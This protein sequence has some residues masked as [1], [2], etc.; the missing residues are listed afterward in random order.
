MLPLPCP[1]ASMAALEDPLARIHRLCSAAALSL[2]SLIATAASA[3]DAR[4]ESLGGVDLLVED[5][6][7]VFSNPALAAVHGNRVFFSLG[8]DGSGDHV[9]LDPHGG[10]LV[11][12]EDMV[13]LGV[14]L[15]RSPLAY[16]FDRALWPVMLQYMPDGPGGIL[17]GPDGPS[18]TTAPL[19]FPAD[20]FLAVGNPWSKLRLGLN[21]YYAGGSERDWIEDDSDQDRLVEGGD[22]KRE[23]HLFGV[24]IGLGAGSLAERTRGEA[25][26][27]VGYMSAWFDEQRSMEVAEN[28][29][30]PTAD[31]VVAM[32]RDVRLGG[33]VRFHLGDVEQGFVVTPGIEYDHAFGAF[34]FD[35]NMVDPDSDSEKAQRD[36]VANDGRAG[37]GVAWRRDGLL[38]D[39][40]VSLR[41]R[42]LKRID[43]LEIEEGID[44]QTF[45]DMAL[46]LPELS[47]GAEYR[48]L[49]VLLVRA[50]VR[51]VVVG[52]RT[53]DTDWI[54]IGDEDTP[55]P[56]GVTQTTRTSPVAMNVA[57][58][59]GLGLEVGRFRADAI[60][61]GLFLG[62]GSLSSGNGFSFFSR[63]DL[64]FSFD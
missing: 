28:E 36:V 63:I 45:G 50:G 60:I 44:R 23:T 2:G 26:V 54:E 10:G 1:G 3:Q 39:G 13:T 64:G 7:N 25:W 34:R 5:S 9:A 58:T 21:L 48:V 53:I 33:G 16:G 56:A 6:S 38:V 55:F 57:A 11:T 12:I 8:I 32:D 15:N 29:A 37:V 4:L 59:G 61:G 46:A 22:F 18:D 62:G 43:T 35:D 47:I 49:P 19:R 52:G 17:E 30:E 14:V 40:T 20:V 51:S 42:H 41:I 31:Q 24:T 27:R